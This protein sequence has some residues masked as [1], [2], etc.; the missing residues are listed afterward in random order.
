MPRIFLVE[1]DPA[2]REWSRLHLG[3]SGFEATAFDDCDRAL[4]ALLV[5]PPDLAMI[6]TNIAG[7]GAF[8][9]AAAIRSSARTARMPILFVV[10]ATDAE[11][12][13]R[14]RAV[15]P[16]AVLSKPFSRDAVSAGRSSSRKNTP[17]LVPPRM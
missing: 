9:L 16:E 10:P 15:D 5:E 11:G 17:L 14:A 3:A 4:E 13:A 6:A 2:L 7:M 12:L 1:Q 8:A